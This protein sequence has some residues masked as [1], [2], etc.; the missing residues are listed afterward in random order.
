MDKDLMREIENINIKYMQDI[1]K[2]QVEVSQ[3]ESSI[4]I[5]RQNGEVLSLSKKIEGNIPS[6]IFCV[7]CSND[8]QKAIIKTL[9]NT[10]WFVYQDKRPFNIEIGDEE[11]LLTTGFRFRQDFLNFEL[12]NQDLIKTIWNK[13]LVLTQEE[14]NQ[15]FLDVVDYFMLILNKSGN[16]R[17]Q[18][19]KTKMTIVEAWNDRDSYV[20]AYARLSMSLHKFLLVAVRDYG[21]YYHEERTIKQKLNGI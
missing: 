9:L 7:T 5:L 13:A 4:K 2:Y 14:F 3:D 11:I 17:F 21:Y 6:D 19:S 20:T 12:S 16:L 1:D 10:G 18:I 15:C 8:E